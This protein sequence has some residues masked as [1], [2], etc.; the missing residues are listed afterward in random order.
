MILF[1]RNL[2]VFRRIMSEQL[3]TAHLISNYVPANLDFHHPHNLEIRRV[4]L[5]PSSYSGT[6]KRSEK[7]SLMVLPC[8]ISLLVQSSPEIIQ[9]YSYQLEDFPVNIS[10][11]WSILYLPLRI[12]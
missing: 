10:Y 8:G 7:S 5:L 2:P 11:M 3:T 4:C 1:R 12:C 9:I 6:N